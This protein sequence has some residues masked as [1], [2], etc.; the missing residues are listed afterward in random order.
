MSGMS[1]ASHRL[2]ARELAAE[3][4][5]AVST[6]SMTPVSAN[7]MLGG[8][9]MSPMKTIPENAMNSKDHTTPVAAVKAAGLVDT[10]SGTGPLT[11]FAPTNSAFDKLPAG[12]VDMLLKPENKDKLTKILT[13]HVVAGRMTSRDIAAAIQQG[14]GKAMLTTVEGESLTATMMGGKLVLA[15]AKGGMS[16]VTIKDVMQSSGVTHLVD[17]VLMP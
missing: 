12:T 7:L 8:A 13:Y 2:E 15:D 3:F 6:I 14:G 1:G 4:A 9:A 11:L 16:T 17:T 5:I 10:L